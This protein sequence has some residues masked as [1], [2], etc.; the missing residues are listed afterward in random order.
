[1]RPGW[2][3]SQGAGVNLLS[4]RY[5]LIRAYR[6]KYQAH[7]FFSLPEKTPQPYPRAPRFRQ[8]VWRDP[9]LRIKPQCL[10]RRL[11]RFLNRDHPF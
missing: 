2:I 3:A 9:A 5:Y 7:R 10:S 6:R 1:M 8:T 11:Y 4:L